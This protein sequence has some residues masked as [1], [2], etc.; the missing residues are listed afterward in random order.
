MVL[1]VASVLSACASP[2]PKAPAQ[3][4]SA[5]VPQAPRAHRTLTLTGNEGNIGDFPGITGGSTGTGGGFVLDYLVVQDTRNSWIPRIA[6]E[7][8]SVEKGTW[9]INADGT[10][11]TIWKIRPNV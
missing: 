11:D 3:G 10:M 9:R 1:I 5:A 6:V 4:S 2:E 7:Q 8:L